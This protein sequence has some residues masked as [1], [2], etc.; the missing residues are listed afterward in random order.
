MVGPVMAGV[1]VEPM[2]TVG[3]RLNSGYRFEAIPDGIAVATRGNGRVDLYVNH[4]TAK[5]PFP[6]NTAA[7]T[8]ANGENDFDNAQVSRLVLNA[9]LGRRAQR[10][11]RHRRS[12]GYQR[13]CSNYLA[14][15]AEGFDRD[16]LFTNEESTDYVY[17]RAAIV[18]AGDRGSGRG[19]G[20]L[21]VR[22]DVRTGK[23][24]ADLR[25]GPPQP[26]ER[27]GDAGL[28]RPVVLTGDDTFT[29]GPLTGVFPAGARARPVAGVLVHRARH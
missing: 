17:R 29:S 4:E 12:D 8:A 25:H 2:I 16:I 9:A 15:A 23:Q 1:T 28:R 18:A 5:V 26:R 3:D 20:G 22:Y 11:V 13:F 21:V 7:P 27:V 14:T 10:L 24:H 6:Y 19:A